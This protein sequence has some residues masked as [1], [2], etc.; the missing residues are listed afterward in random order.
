[1]RVSVLIALSLGFPFIG[2][3]RVEMFGNVHE[4]ISL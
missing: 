1:M 3:A 4:H 2:K